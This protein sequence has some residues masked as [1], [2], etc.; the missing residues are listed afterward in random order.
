MAFHASRSGLKEQAG[1]LYL[2]LAGRTAARHAYLDAELLYKNAIE[3]F[4]EANVAGQ[5]SA[6]Q[7][8]A[9]MRFRLGRYEDSLKDFTAA[10][11]K[12]HQANN[13]AAVAA[14]LL[15]EG[16]VLDWASDW[17]GSRKVSEEAITLVKAHEELRTPLVNARLLMAEGRSYM[18]QE[19]IP[20]AIDTLRRAVQAAEPLG[21]EGYEPFTQSLSMVGYSAGILNRFDE[22]EEAMSRCLEVFE[23]HGD[24]VG[25]AATL[26]N[27]AITS[28]LT[29]RI[30]R[31]LSDFKRI[32]QI[33]REYGYPMSEATVNRD[34][35]EVYFM[36]GQPEE[37]EPYTRRA[38]DMFKRTIGGG[39]RAESCEGLLVRL[40]WV[41]GD[42][43]AAAEL[44]NVLNARQAAAEA[45]GQT[46]ALVLPTERVILDAVA[47]GLRGA[48]DAEFDVL[49]AK[50]REL[51]M[52]AMDMVELYEMKAVSALRAGRRADG[53]RL[54]EEALAEADK[55]AQL[56]SD[57]LRRQLD[58]A[59]AAAPIAAQGS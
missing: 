33:A 17:P 39:S 6:G 26:Q 55:N 58:R 1:A 47:H 54:L 12:A 36:I 48:T 10:I 52:Q 38:I 23:A 29:N 37:A 22:A 2:D 34:L 44:L 4:P 28:F 3:N 13:L 7:G 11:E 18:R 16:I 49:I 59:T 24:M 57:R 56:T 14:M 30:D 27:R 43:E 32:S 45:A 46:N 41:A 19:K 35:G 53:I 5:I 42:L 25:I 40:K 21:D 8:R 15:D 20:E 51:A 50:G 31:V 9:L